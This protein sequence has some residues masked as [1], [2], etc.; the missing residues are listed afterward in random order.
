MS[1]PCLDDRQHDAGDVIRLTPDEITELGITT[2]PART[3]LLRLETEL[4]GEI[5]LNVERTAHV[6]PTLPGVTESVQKTIGDTV[7]TGDVLAI[8]KSPE[9]A[10]AKSL[11]LA[12]RE[13]V[14]LALSRFEREETLCRAMHDRPTWF[15]RAPPRGTSRRLP[16]ITADYYGRCKQDPRLTRHLRAIRSMGSSSY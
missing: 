2:A 8:I 15:F 6:F 13:R 3:R 10:D 11:F 5:A 9:L 4:L 1:L 14:S 12:N 7:A 16:Q